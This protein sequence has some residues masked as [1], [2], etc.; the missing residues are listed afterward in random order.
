MGAALSALLNQL[1]T[2]GSL[3]QRALLWFPAVAWFDVLSS[4]VGGPTGVLHSGLARCAIWLLGS[5]VLAAL[6]LPRAL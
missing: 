4:I 5:G 2:P 1:N 6:C 3:A